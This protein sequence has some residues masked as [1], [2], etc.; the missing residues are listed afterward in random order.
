MNI[1]LINGSPKKKDSAS[2]IVL[3]ELKS[4]L[5]DN[6]ITETPV[7]FNFFMIYITLLI[8][9]DPNAEK[10]SSISNMRVSK[11]SA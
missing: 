2:E 1:V 6:N 9:S 7:A 11:T 4:L 3:T 10:A 8:S 5:G